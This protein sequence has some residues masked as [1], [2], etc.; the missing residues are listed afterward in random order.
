M[1]NAMTRMIR[2]A[3]RGAKRASNALLGALAVTLLKGLRLTNPDRM[4]DF[5]GWLMRT[6]GPL[7]PENRIGRDNLV[8]AFPEKSAAEIGIILRG[9]WDNL[10]RMGACDRRCD[11]Q[12]RQRGALSAA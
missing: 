6:L 4:A 2:L 8:A 3:R 9:A 11:L 10:G 7:L 5:A 12:A 1:P